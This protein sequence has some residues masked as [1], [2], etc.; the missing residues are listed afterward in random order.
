MDPSKTHRSSSP[1]V[2]L[3]LLTAACAP[4]SEDLRNE[5]AQAS[6]EFSAYGELYSM[7]EQL[8]HSGDG[9]WALDIDYY[10]ENMRVEMTRIPATRE[11]R[12]D[13]GLWV[14]ANPD[15]G[16]RLEYK[17]GSLS[18]SSKGAEA[19]TH[20]IASVC[21]PQNERIFALL[22]SPEDRSVK[23]IVV[24]N[25]ILTDNEYTLAPGRAL[26]IM[27]DP[28]GKLF[29]L[30]IDELENVSVMQ[31]PV[32]GRISHSTSEW[33][34]QQRN[35]DF[36]NWKFSVSGDQQPAIELAIPHGIM[37]GTGL[38]EFPERKIAEGSKKL[39]LLGGLVESQLLS[40]GG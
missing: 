4:S 30:Q 3:G 12:E 24:S 15:Q 40:W 6:A 31:E 5:R 20:A 2:A 33:E 35:W 11:A 18:L 25:E 26:Q 10:F 27:G 14:A 32:S 7:R 16:G 34:G 28:V 17:F 13:L 39:E 38:W 29:S 1:L 21:D 36:S 37:C 9:V 22:S 8:K 19:L 23:V